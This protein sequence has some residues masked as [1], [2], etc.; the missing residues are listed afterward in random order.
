MKLLYKPL[1]LVISV[2]GGLIASALFSRAWKLVAHEDDAPKAIEAHRGWRE[3]LTAAALQGA[4]FGVVK[5]AG[6]CWPT[7]R[8]RSVAGTRDI[9]AGRPGSPRPPGPGPATSRRRSASRGTGKEGQPWR[10]HPASIFT[11]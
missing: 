10:K 9:G 7:R 4:V 8:P 5:A 2:I 6:P 1:G 3:V 11:T